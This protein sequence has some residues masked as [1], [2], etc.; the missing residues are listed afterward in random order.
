MVI[1]TES[2]K[3]IDMTEIWRDIKDYEGLYQVSNL[4][5]VKNLI[6]GK[7]LK[8]ILQKTGYFSVIL[9]KNGIKT[10]YLIHRLVA[11]AFIPNPENKP[12]IDH[13]NRVRNDNRI[14]NLHWVTHKENMN[15]PL[16][17]QFLSENKKGKYFGRY[18]SEHQYSK[19]VLQYDKE[20][21]FIKEWE[22][23]KTASIELS[24]S[25]TA[26]NNCLK[27]RSKTAGG[28]IWKFKD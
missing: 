27:K 25:K 20:G 12:C 19:S 2:C 4:G 14:E 7:I 17:K 8:Q 16:T 22:C 18:G 9:C 23:E 21:N 1:C 3:L 10:L 15:N 13:I 28:Y 5:R 6:T 26:I 11:E 24:I